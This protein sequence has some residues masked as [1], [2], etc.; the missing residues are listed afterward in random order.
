MQPKSVQVKMSGDEDGPSPF[1]GIGPDDPLERVNWKVCL[2]I[3]MENPQLMKAFHK[4]MNYKWT[5]ATA[6]ADNGFAMAQ[7]FG[8]WHM[9]NVMGKEKPYAM[10]D[11][12]EAAEAIDN[13]TV[14]RQAEGYRLATFASRN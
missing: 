10:C 2:S 3:A 9:N 4:S 1:D 14:E 11:D 6:K 7:D 5:P 12:P 13:E 8:H